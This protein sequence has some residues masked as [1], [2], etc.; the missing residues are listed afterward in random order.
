MTRTAPATLSNYDE[1]LKTYYLPGIQDYL[2]NANPLS[3][4]VEPNEEDIS[5]KN[6]TIEC[7]Y[8]RSTGTG[9]RS[10]GESLP[11]AA[12]QQFQTCTVPMQY[13][14]GRIEVTGPTIAATRDSKGAYAKALDTEIR[15]IVDDLK[16]EVNRMMW[17]CGYGVLA[18]WRTTASGTSYTIQ[19]MYRGNSAGG[20][21]FGSAF[22]G[23]YLDKRGDAVPVVVASISSNNNATTTVDATNIAVSALTKG[24]QFDT[25]TVTDPSVS[26]AAATFY[27]RPASL[28]TTAA[29]GG[30]RKE[31]MGLRGLVSNEDLDNIAISNGTYTGLA[32][33][34]PLQTL[35]VGSYS[36]FVSIVD[37]HS[38]GRYAGQRSLTLD[39]IQT[40]FDMVEEQA[41]KD[42][43][44]NIM[45]TTRAIR[46]EYLELMR[47][48]RRNVN[49]MELDGGWTALDYNGVPFMV[50]NDAIDGE[51]YFLTLKDLQLYRMS[52]YNWMEKDAAVLSRISG[53]DTYEAVLFRYA[54]FGIKNR[55]T[56]GVLTDISYNKSSV[57]GYGR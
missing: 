9:A 5:G 7:H 38:S 14:Y 36:W 3:A 48:D 33:N 34:D 2:N 51:I 21:A 23:K 6:A 19:K 13:I 55:A 44:P 35:A 49:T 29:S 52:D 18:R 25:I 17:G 42:Y 16:V 10:D 56:Q 12:Y 43:G 32:T 40:M 20:D 31:I 11:A 1:V 39:L 30:H 57:E 4:L 28:G 47:A 24:A 26:E 27:V 22:G 41:G 54:E 15:G 37:S 8:G 50:D 53:Y 45:F 46:R